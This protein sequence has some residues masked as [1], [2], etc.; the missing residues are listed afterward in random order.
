ME[1]LEMEMEMETEMEMEM[2]TEMKLLQGSVIT[3]LDYWT[4][5]YYLL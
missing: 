3:G 1:K 5:P 2:K 4:Y